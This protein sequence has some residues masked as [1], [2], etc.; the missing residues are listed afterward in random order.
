MIHRL[1]RSRAGFTLVELIV[2]IAILAILAGVAIP[3]YSGYI[4]KANEAADLQLLGAVNTAFAAA[5]AGRGLDPTKINAAPQALED[6]CLKG[7]AAPAELNE[8]FLMYYGENVETPFKVYTSLGYDRVNGVFV[9]GGK[10]YSF[11]TANGV[12]T[13]TAA[14]LSSYMAS[15]FATDMEVEELTGSVDLLAERVLASDSGANFIMNNEDFLAFLEEM[16][17][18]AATQEE[19][20]RALVLYAASGS[21]ANTDTWIDQL[22]ENG[23]ISLGELEPGMP[24]D[25]AGSIKTNAALFSLMTAYANSEYAKKTVQ[26]V[27]EVDSLINLIRAYGASGR[28]VVSTLT[29]KLNEVYGEGN[30]ELV[31]SDSSTGGDGL[32]HLSY[33]NEFDPVSYYDSE[34]QGLSSMNGISTMMDTFLTDDNFRQYLAEQGQTD[35]NGFFSTMDMINANTAAV[36]LDQLL[37]AGFSD[38]DS[39]VIDLINTILG[40]NP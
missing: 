20:A 3:V 25:Y 22:L 15:T 21:T 11:A 14:Q 13:V 23:S 28:P 36:D 5:C 1:K 12:V 7:I 27:E 16:G 24:I 39:G 10:E 29:T 31:F 38:E 26:D 6:G 4:A 34:I 32:W 30:Y 2:V 17:L 40:N 8:D 35:L 33:T 18:S 19:K 37:S 9:D